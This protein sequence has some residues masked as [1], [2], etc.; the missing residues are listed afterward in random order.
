MCLL[1]GLFY[2]TSDRDFVWT[3]SE[4]C[5]PQHT[6]QSLWRDRSMHRQSAFSR[7]VQ[8][9]GEQ[10]AAFLSLKVVSWTVTCCCWFDRVAFLLAETGG[11]HHSMIQGRYKET[12]LSK[13]RWQ[14]PKHQAETTGWSSRWE[15]LVGVKGEAELDKKPRKRAGGARRAWVAWDISRTC[16]QRFAFKRCSILQTNDFS[17][18]YKVLPK[19]G[20]LYG[21]LQAF[22]VSLGFVTN[23]AHC[24]KEIIGFC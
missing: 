13:T 19:T 6:I 23:I 2:I 15:A 1:E 24:I 17:D 3:C 9:I 7:F 20:S 5:L 16:F 10:D 4:T 14:S 22:F 21:L 18:L 8:S 11:C 12:D